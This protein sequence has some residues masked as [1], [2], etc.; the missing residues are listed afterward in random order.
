MT[1]PKEALKQL[2]EFR[3]RLSRDTRQRI[4]FRKK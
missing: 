1:L 2:R 4:V 3:A